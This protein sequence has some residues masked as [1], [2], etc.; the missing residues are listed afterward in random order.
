LV[1]IKQ[2]KEMNDISIHMQFKLVKSANSLGMRLGVGWPI[3]VSWYIA[4][5]LCTTSFINDFEKV[6]DYTLRIG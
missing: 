3:L 5:E 1:A 6:L 4:L 2:P